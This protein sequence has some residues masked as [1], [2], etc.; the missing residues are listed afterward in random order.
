[1]L[2]AG[3]DREL[4]LL[5]GT[6]LQH[7]V[8]LLALGIVEPR[9]PTVAVKPLDELFWFGKPEI[10]LRLIQ[11]I[12]FQ[13]AFKMAT[14]VWS[15]SKEDHEVHVRLVLELL[16]KERLL[17]KFFKCEFWLQENQKYEWGMEQEEAF[18]TL[19]ENLCN[20]PIL[21]LPD[22]AEDFVVYCDASNQG[23]PQ[24]QDVLDPII[25]YVHAPPEGKVFITTAKSLLLLL[26]HDVLDP[27]IEPVL[28]RN[29]DLEVMELENT[30]NNALAKLPML[31]LEE[32]EMWEIRIKQY[33]QIQDY[34]LWEVIENENSW[35]PIPVT[36]PPESN[37]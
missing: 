37:R 9:G 31:K 16:K 5:V 1:M 12:S 3:V 35:V 26:V 13:N 34:A 24:G 27:V 33:F 17:A 15:V 28:M 20:A 19:K 7:V 30:Q 21:L 11:F 36:T 29:F 8:S 25:G 23:L 6:K 22:G 2:V 32:Y 14:F 18:R 4:A 10:F